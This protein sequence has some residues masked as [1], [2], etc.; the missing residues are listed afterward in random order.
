MKREYIK[1]LIAKSF[2]EIAHNRNG[3]YEVFLKPLKGYKIK[4]YLVK[5][6]VKNSWNRPYLYLYTFNVFGDRIVSGWYGDSQTFEIDLSIADRDIN[7]SK[8]RHYLGDFYTSKKDAYD[9][10]IN[11]LRN[12]KRELNKEIMKLQND[13]YSA[14]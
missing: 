2:D 9:T 4:R 8:I 11:M 10:A 6:E 5:A 3:I 13:L 1:P 14:E 7:S 12:K